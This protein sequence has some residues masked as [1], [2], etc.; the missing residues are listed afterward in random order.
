MKPD[1]VV[2][3]IPNEATAESEEQEIH[4][5]SWILNWSLSFGV[6]EWDCVVVHP[7]VLAT[8]TDASRAKLIRQLV[9][10]QHLQLI[11]REMDTVASDEIIGR[12]FE[13]ELRSQSK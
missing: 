5:I 3:T 6:Q 1:L 7:S 4:S 13:S 2:L 9:H 11:D 12:W 8:G 10:A